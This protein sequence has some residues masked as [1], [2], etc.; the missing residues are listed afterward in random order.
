MSPEQLEGKKYNYKVDIWSL[1][2]IFFELLNSFSTGMERNVTLTKI[3]KQDYPAS[4]MKSY[5]EE[6]INFS[7]KIYFHN[8]HRLDSSTSCLKRCYQQIQITGQLFPI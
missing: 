7:S 1:G 4:F 2:I 3:T 6:V 5:A 8:E